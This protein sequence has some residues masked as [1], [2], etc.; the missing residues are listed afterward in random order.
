MTA[1]AVKPRHAARK[2]PGV[3]RKPLMP[4][5]EW[6][7]RS[8]AVAKDM[9]MCLK[10]VAVFDPEVRAR[11]FEACGHSSRLVEETREEYTLKRA[12]ALRALA[13]LEQ[14]AV[15]LNGLAYKRR[16]RVG[17]LY[18]EG[19]DDGGTA[20]YMVVEAHRDWVAL[21]LVMLRGTAWQPQWI[22]QHGGRIEFDRIRNT[23]EPCGATTFGPAPAVPMLACHLPQWKNKARLWLQI[24][25]VWYY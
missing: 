10:A 22:F 21:E 9:R 5:P 24:L 7:R 15:A 20:V 2:R 12:R 17:R 1:N 19:T 25:G 4:Y 3:K 6:V 8:R 16:S 18:K 14:Q 13:A 11:R 23:L